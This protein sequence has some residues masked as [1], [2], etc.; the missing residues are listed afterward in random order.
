MIIHISQGKE[1]QEIVA[2]SENQ[3]TMEQI[4]EQLLNF[5]MEK[6]WKK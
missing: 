1:P 6:S 2:G 4:K 5:T 3:S